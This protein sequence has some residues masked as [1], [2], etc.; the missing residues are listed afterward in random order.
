[1]AAWSLVIGGPGF[2]LALAS[3]S[4]LGCGNNSGV[5]Q[6]AATEDRAGVDGGAAD[7]DFGILVVTADAL[8]QVTIVHGECAAVETLVAAPRDANVGQAIQL[9][10]SGIASGTAPSGVVITWA[11][12][13]SAGTLAASTGPSNAFNCTSAGSSTV[14]VTASIADGGASCNDG[15]SLAVVVDCN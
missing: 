1:M 14:T 7:S 8:A 15:G 6:D 2:G 13:G 5:T 10:A 3:A 9:T 12:A 11:A 4:L